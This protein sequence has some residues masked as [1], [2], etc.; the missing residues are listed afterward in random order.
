MEGRATGEK[1]YYLASD[2]IASMLKY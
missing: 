1:G 2:Y